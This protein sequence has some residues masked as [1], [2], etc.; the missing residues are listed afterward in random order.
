L[1]AFPQG[2]MTI[3]RGQRFKVRGERFSSDVRGGVFNT[4]G[5]GGLECIAK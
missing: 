1:E 3:T 5:G 2:K 4:E